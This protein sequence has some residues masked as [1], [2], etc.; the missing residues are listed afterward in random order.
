MS[1]ILVLG[2]AFIY[3]IVGIGY[4][5]ESKLGLGVTFICYAAANIGLYLTARGF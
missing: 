2:V 5:N 1:N 3:L 4:I